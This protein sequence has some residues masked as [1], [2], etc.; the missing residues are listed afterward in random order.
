MSESDWQ[1][2][3]ARSVAVFLNGDAIAE[4]DGRGQRVTDDSFL[5]L[6][7]GHHEDMDFT[8]PREVYGERWEAVLDTSAPVVDDRPSAKAGEQVTLESRSILVLRRVV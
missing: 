8:I 1:V 4:P 7:N 2:G 6:F 3:Y 5:L